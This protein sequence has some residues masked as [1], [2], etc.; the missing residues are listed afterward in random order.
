M[1][2]V[3]YFVFSDNTVLVSAFNVFG[4]EPLIACIVFS[5][6]LVT[7]LNRLVIRY[8]LEPLIVCIACS[9]LVT[10]EELHCVPKRQ[11]LALPSAVTY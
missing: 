6:M 7:S 5:E 8:G 11:L 3:H 2:R 9:L 1:L 10:S 4:F